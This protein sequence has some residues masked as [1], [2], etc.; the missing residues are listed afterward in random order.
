VAQQGPYRHFRQENGTRP[1]RGGHSNP[2]WHTYTYVGITGLLL[3][4]VV[5]LAGGMTPG[6]MGADLAAVDLGRFLREQRITETS[7]AF[8]FTKTAR[9]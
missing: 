1:H 9:S 5:A 6:V 3:L 8:I 2:P 4:I 7:T